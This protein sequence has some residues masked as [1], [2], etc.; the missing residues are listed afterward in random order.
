M[1]RPTTHRAALLLAA[2]FAPAMLPAARAEE[3]QPARL[4]QADTGTPAGAGTASATVLPEVATQARGNRSSLEPTPG[5]VAPA[6]IAGGKVD[7][8]LVETPQSISVVTRDE[9]DARQAQT[10]GE[11]LRFV[12]GIRTEPY[13]PD[14]RY[15]WFT[16]RGFQAQE[17]SIFLNGLRY[18]FG[19][20]V[21]MLEPYGMERIE[22]V[23]GPTSVLYGQINP[24][25]L[26][27][28]VQRRPTD[29]AQGEVRL[30]AGTQNRVQGAFN[31]S[32]PLTADGRWSYSLTGLFRDSGT[33]VDFV[34]ND[35][36]YIAPALTFRPT[37][38]TRIT[39]LAYYQRDLTHG[40]EFLPAL[41]TLYPSVYGR[42]PTYRFSGNPN[43][44]HFNRTQYGVGY[45]IE[46]R[47]NDV[48]TVRQNARFGH[49][50]YD[51]QQFYGI[52]NVPGT[53]G[54]L[55]YRFPF[56]Q[57][58][59]LESFQVDNQ[60]EARFATGPVRHTVLAGV[61]YAHSFYA[62][63]FA[64]APTDTIDLYNPVY[65]TPAPSR[66]SL[67]SASRQIGDQ[68]GLYAQDQLRLDRFVMT[69]G[70][71]QDWADLGTFNRV[72][73]AR[74][75]QDDS[76]LTW[77]AGLTYLFDSGVAPYFSYATSFQPQ[78]GVGYYGQTYRPTTGEQYELGVKYQPP[79]RRS[80]VQAAMFQLTQQN[81]LTTDPG[82]NLNQVQT[83]EIRVR[84][85]ELEAVANLTP[86]LNVRAQYTYLDPTIT[87]S[88]V[89]GEQGR[90]PNGIP[91]TTAGAY[92]D[93]QFGEGRGVLSG[94]GLGGGVR[95]VGNT[96]AGNTHVAIVPSV[97]LF[98]ASLRYSLSALNLGPQLDRV[99]MQVNASNLFDKQ[100]VASCGSLSSCF[101]GLRRTVI[102]SLVY[103][104]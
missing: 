32:G 85:V 101:W 34:K 66:F 56:Q 1:I 17:N 37:D 90:R 60:A 20:L 68:V 49:T 47:F 5:F 18:Q 103:R 2:A 53:A 19:S 102:G 42:I 70:L 14:N 97:T 93:Y 67:S 11:A 58:N 71:R 15:D 72:T 4:A 40:D 76:K 6:S 62:T 54:R 61:D 98:D 83:G 51:W 89:A 39:L 78:I 50:D 95:F 10:V 33:Q 84:G 104:W 59:T 46:H 26:V 55:L 57:G 30:S 80:F 63:R 13:G 27:N 45:E 36:T 24:G 64:T 73:T 74:T 28:L 21:G 92:A 31:T 35:R 99:S 8:P 43:G 25:G 69:V 82:N 75:S 100:Y 16:L 38:D 52:G 29:T 86:G 44:D 48:F 12:P 7:T 41:G 87:R 91:M 88:N 77:R 9:I 79:G 22:V 81:V 94:V 65:S 3:A 96:P 23:R